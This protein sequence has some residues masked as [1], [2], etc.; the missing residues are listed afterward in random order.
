MVFFVIGVLVFLIIIVFRKYKSI[1]SVIISLAFITGITTSV[2]IWGLT[3]VS[4]QS[5]I[6]FF[7]TG[8]G[9]SEFYHLIAA[10]YCMDLLCAVTIIKRYRDYKKIN[11]I[12]RDDRP[13][14]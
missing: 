2:L 5:E 12:P 13:L 3:K 4:G 1:Y 6:Q 9:K 7:Y 11:S 14:S 8:I 10:W